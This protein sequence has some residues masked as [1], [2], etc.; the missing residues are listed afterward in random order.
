MATGR[1][2]DRPCPW[3]S[4]AVAAVPAGPASASTARSGAGHKPRLRRAGRVRPAARHRFGRWPG[5][6]PSPVGRPSRYC[7]IWH[8]ESGSAR[9]GSP[10]AR[11]PVLRTAMPAAR[12]R[13]AWAAETPRSLT[14]FTAST[15]NS[16][17]NLRRCMTHLQLHETPN[18][19]VHQSGRR[20]C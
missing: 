19:G 8:W 3:A 16:R 5:S 11:R 15:L 1:A 10:T 17:L 12:S 14:S 18:L 9:H 7:G 13:A 20:P 2:G 4:A 6:S